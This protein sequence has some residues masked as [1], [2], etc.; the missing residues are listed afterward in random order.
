MSDK[1]FNEYLFQKY[2]KNDISRRKFMGTLAAAGAS[3]TVINSLLSK[4]AHAATPKRG[5]RL[6]VGM[7]QATAQDSLDPTSYWGT[8]N[9]LMGNC[10][11]DWLVNR[12]PDLNPAP[13][14]ATSWEPNADASSWVFNLRT[15]V[16]WHDGAKFTADDVMY[17]CTRHFREG[18]ESPAKAYMSTIASMDKLSDHQL[19]F[20]LTAPNADFPVVLS[21]TRVQITQ[22]GREDF[23]N[24]AGTGPFKVVDFTPGSRYVFERNDNYWGDDGPYVDEVEFVGIPDPTAKINALLA[25]DINCILQLDQ[26]AARLINNS[27]SSYVIDAP[28][29]AFLNLAM[30]VDREPTNNNDFRLA[31]KHAMDREG[32][33][34]N[35][36]KGFGSV[37]NDHPI[38]PISPYYNSDLPQR[39]YDPD[40][41]NFHIKKAGLENTPIDFYGSDV[42]GSG[43]LACAQHLQQSAKKANINLNVI[44]PP[45]DSYWSAVW[46]QKP[47]IV[48]GWDARPVPDLIFAIAFASESGWNE[49]LWKNDKFDKLMVSARSDTDFESRKA[50]YFE[51]QEM[52]HNH[53]GHGTLG[54]RNYVDAASNEVQ[55]INPHGSGPLGFYQGPRTAWIDS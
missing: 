7:E 13:F 19:R 48:S 22:N 49:T 25:G 26:K 18:T 52:L 20:N 28:S 43:G 55:G 5:G 50:K 47:I 53:G 29:G 39:T 38:A 10:V 36:L 33:V 24:P 15:D 27:G 40:K 35:V 21:D 9:I 17:S 8:G 11:H 34:N 41:A 4:R 42:A 46:I 30:M 37:G 6:V 1:K 32:L 23:S 54:F 45:A 51:M 16:E 2:L 14:L 31:I 44:N 3:S 12:G